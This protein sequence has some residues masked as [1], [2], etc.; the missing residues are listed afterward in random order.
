MLVGVQGGASGFF[1]GLGKGLLGAVVK[2]T[3]GLMDLTSKSAQAACETAKAGKKTDRIRPPR[4]N[5][6]DGVL[7]NYDVRS[8]HGCDA[9]RRLREGSWKDHR[10][11]G[12]CVLEKGQAVVVTDRHVC[13]HDSAGLVESWTCEIKELLEV[14]VLD[15]KVSL[16][17][18]AVRCV[19]T[20]N[21]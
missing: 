12:Y 9:M 2:P 11:V 10:Y 8:A 18:E 1:S 17:V 3:A 21:M 6:G 7:R 16:T 20:G 19:K 4:V 13:A 15:K 5:L 14:K